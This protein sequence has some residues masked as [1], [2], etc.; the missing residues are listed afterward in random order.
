MLPLVTTEIS[1]FSVG[2]ALIQTQGW[3]CGRVD[4]PLLLLPFLE[5]FHNITKLKKVFLKHG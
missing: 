3:V 1:D 2:E 4:P 5:T